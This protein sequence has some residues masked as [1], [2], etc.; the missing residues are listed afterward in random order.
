MYYL[1]ASVELATNI[2]YTTI[3]F[4]HTEVQQNAATKN[5]LPYSQMK[6]VGNRDDLRL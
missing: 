4:I 5:I 2:L 6:K 3:C 1:L